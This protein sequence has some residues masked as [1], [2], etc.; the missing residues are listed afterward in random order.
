MA[1]KSR[2][3]LWCLMAWEG[4]VRVWDFRWWHSSKLAYLPWADCCPAALVQDLC[5]G[6]AT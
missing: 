5:F 2:A 3:W 1:L 6:R 4:L